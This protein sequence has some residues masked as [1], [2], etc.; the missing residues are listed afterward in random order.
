MN[1]PI[2]DFVK[3]YAEGD[4]LRLHMP[5]HKGE[6]LLGVEALDITEIEGADVLYSAKGIIAESEKNAST[7][8]GSG[9]TVYSTEGSSLSI[10]AMLYLALL[11]GKAQG[12]EPVI[13][14]VRNAHRVFHSAAALLDLRVEWLSGENDTLLSSSVTPEI[15][16]TAL[17]HTDRRPFAVYL[18]TPDDLGNTLDIKGLSKVAEKYGVLCIVDNA[19]GAYL[20]FLEIS[21]HPIHLGAHMC[22]DSAHKTLPALTGAGYLHISKNAPSLL[23]DEVENAMALFASTSPSYLILQSLDRVNKYLSDGYAQK[24]QTFCEKVESLKAELTSHGYRAIGDEPLKLSI[25]AKAYGYMG[26]E[27][28]A[29]LSG[30]SIVCEH[31]D[32][33]TVVLM[34]TPEVGEGGLARLREALLSIEKREKINKKPPR[35]APRRAV[36]SA[37]EAIMSPKEKI[38]AA[39]SQGRVLADLSVSCPPAVPIVSCGE[40]IDENA[41][42]LFRYYGIDTV[43]VV[44]ELPS[45]T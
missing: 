45:E 27:L 16:D 43:S 23:F 26:E 31:A 2:C 41:V 33:D 20:N 25:D 35:L 17:S 40:I 19:H 28:S 38:S 42:E 18:T 32:R 7:L 15:L 24:L 21:R 14:A 13:F 3:S 6:P 8:F 29:T 44:R 34:L 1:T 4:S 30:K 12:R 37:R 39:N 22:A 36:M 9:K 11:W 5:G 10:R